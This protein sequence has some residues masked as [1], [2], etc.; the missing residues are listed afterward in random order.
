MAA[1]KKKYLQSNLH[2]VG[3]MMGGQRLLS[4]TNWYDKKAAKPKKQG[5]KE[6]QK[7]QVKAKTTNKQKTEEAQQ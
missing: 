3:L 1:G 2:L 6:K 7:A 4:L 5:K